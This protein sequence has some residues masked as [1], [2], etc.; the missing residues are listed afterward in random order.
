MDTKERNEPQPCEICGN[1][2]AMQFADQWICEECYQ[3]R[4]SCCP[5]FGKDDLW[6]FEEDQQEAAEVEVAVEK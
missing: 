1:P 3:G 5:E 2:E 6:V 4:S